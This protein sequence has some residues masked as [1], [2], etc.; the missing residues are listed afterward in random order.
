MKK[1]I[2]ALATLLILALPAVVLAQTYYTNSYGVWGY[3]TTSGAVTITQFQGYGSVS[4]GSNDNVIIPGSINGLPVTGIA[5]GAFIDDYNYLGSVTI[6]N[7]VTSIGQGA[8]QE[9]TYMTNVLVGT[10]VTNI[11]NNAFLGDNSSLKGIY[12]LGNAPSYG[13]SIFGGTNPTVYYLPSATGWSN[14]ACTFAGKFPPY[15]A[16]EPAAAQPLGVATYSNQPVLFFA[17]PAAF[18]ASLG[19][20]YVLQMRTNLASSNWVTVTS[21]GV[22]LISIQITN[23]PSNAFF[24]LQ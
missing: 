20:N 14:Y 19:T 7:S 3:V 4:T 1:P 22:A 18:P 5:A 6:P 8:F 12:F 10:G 16:V 23:A 9:C 21:N 13:S 15:R 11:G 2:L 24:R 17:T